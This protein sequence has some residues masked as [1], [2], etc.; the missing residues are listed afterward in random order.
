MAVLR[1]AVANG[2]KNLPE[3]AG[4]STLSLSRSMGR[5][6]RHARQRAGRLLEA[7]VGNWHLIPSP[8]PAEG[9]VEQ[10][11][12]VKDR[13]R[14]LLDRYGILFRELL[15]RELPA[16]QWPSIFRS[17]R[18]MELAGE[19]V[20]GSFFE[21]IPGLQFASRRMLERLRKKPSEDAVYWMHAKDP[22]SLCGLGIEALKSELP[23][24]TNGTHLVYLGSRLVMVSRRHGND[25][26]INLP[27][28]H[29][30]LT[31]C[32]VVFDHL[33]G[34]RFDPLRSLSV[35]SINGEAAA[36]SPYLEAL[37]QRFDVVVEPRAVSLYRPVT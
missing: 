33:L 16:F 30:R 23:R 2:F 8:V 14:L 3:A 13:V 32:F 24:R 19:V 20:M 5:S 10:E 18:L 6:R 31:D 36:A 28:D 34:R 25:L 27:A 12:L 11:E 22:A 15:T 21:D 1:S 26:R 4:L 35:A 7:S 17:L 9:L 29:C 37:R